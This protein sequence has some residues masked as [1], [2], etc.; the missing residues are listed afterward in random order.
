MK[1]TAVCSCRLPKEAATALEREGVGLISLPPH[2]VLQKTTA[3][4]ADMLISVVDKTVFFDKIYFEDNEDLARRIAD[5]GGYEITVVPPLGKKY[6]RDASLNVLVAEKFAVMNMKTASLD[7]LE[8]ITSSGRRIVN[9]RQGYAAC[10]CLYFKGLLVTAD[11]GIARAA[12]DVCEVLEIGDGGV[13][14]P[15]YNEG[16][17]GGASGVDGDAV[18]FAGDLSLHPDGD[19]IASAI[20]GRGGR[21]VSL[22]DGP[23]F[24]VG[25]I[26][27]I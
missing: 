22:T 8:K 3:C 19:R 17:I 16:F 13:S 6:P 11:H 10:S 25:G 18:Y 26:K 2:R 7:L 21:V 27:F 1:R 20:E 15:P 4:H 14:L 9:V 23:L 5:A 12:Q 24:D